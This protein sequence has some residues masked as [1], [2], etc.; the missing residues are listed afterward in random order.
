VHE[1]SSWLARKNLLRASM[2]KLSIVLIVGNDST[3]SVVDYSED[4]GAASNA[5]SVRDLERDTGANDFIL[6]R[7]LMSVPMKVVLIGLEE[8]VLKIGKPICNC[9]EISNGRQV[10]RKLVEDFDSLSVSQLFLDHG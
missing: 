7:K 5:G 1:A 4:S 9:A 2:E 3:A 10:G 6:P 8:Q